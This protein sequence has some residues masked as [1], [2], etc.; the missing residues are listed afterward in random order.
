MQWRSGRT[1]SKTWLQFSVTGMN[2]W[3]FNTSAPSRAC[4]LLNCQPSCF[5]AACKKTLWNTLKTKKWLLMCK[6]KVSNGCYKHFVVAKSDTVW[7][8]HIQKVLLFFSA[9]FLYPTVVRYGNLNKTASSDQKNASYNVKPLIMSV[10]NELCLWGWKS[11]EW[12]F[13]NWGR[14]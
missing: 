2:F 5:Y 7:S 8:N 13:V 11:V 10:Q 1:F 4:C 6:K 9:L 3:M 14:W 12:V